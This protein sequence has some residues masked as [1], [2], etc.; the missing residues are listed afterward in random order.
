MRNYFLP[1]NQIHKI[2]ILSCSFIFLISISTSAQTDLNKFKEIVKKDSSQINALAGYDAAVRKDILT[3]AQHPEVLTQLKEKQQASQAAFQN[4]IDK[5]DRDTQFGIYELSRY[6]NLLKELTLEGKL[7]KRDI[8]NIILSYPEEIH[9]AALKYGRK[10]YKE[11]A[12]IDHLNEKNK[13]DFEALISNYNTEFQNSIKRLIGTP[14]IL[15]TMVDHAEFTRLAGSVYQQ[16]PE[17]MDAQLEIWHNQIKEAKAK[18]L[19]DYEKKIKEDPEAYEEMLAA[20]EQFAAEETAN[21]KITDPVKQEVEVVHVNHYSYWYG[22]PYW[23]SYPYWRPYPW[24]Y[25]T[26]FYYGSGG[27]IFIGMPSY[28]YVGW[29]HRYYPNRY[30]HLT[31]HYYRHAHRHPR[32]YYNFRRTVNV[33]INNN[34]NIDRGSLAKID[35]NRGNIIPKQWPKERPAARPAERPA[36]KPATRPSTRPE[37]RP[38][39]RPATRPTN[40][41]QGPVTKP[42][43]RP[44][45]RPST[46][47]V[48]KPTTRPSTRPVHYNNYRSNENF[49]QNWSRPTSPASRPVNRPAGGANFRR[50]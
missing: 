16:Y 40:P 27:V 23:Y 43:T 17:R 5:Y 31:Y 35:H 26:G 15:S 12:A 36:N 2:W 18:E 11:L 4:I 46:R 29:H 41:T 3:V 10:R 39:Q 1:S 49:R 42:A 14:E 45:T 6:P 33:N 21:K 22:Y 37:A 9:E 13:H 32:S 28:W 48:N 34:I 20:A 24:Y 7:K 50:R 8:E 25:H 47:P 38:A 19:A 30:P 44:A